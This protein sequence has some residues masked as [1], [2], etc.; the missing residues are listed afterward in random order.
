MRK[1]NGAILYP[2]T[3]IPVDAAKNRKSSNKGNIARI[4]RFRM[5]FGP[6]RSQRRELKF[7]IFERTNEQTNEQNERKILKTSF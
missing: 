5:I 1:L 7:E 6:N 2:L 3:P 4:A